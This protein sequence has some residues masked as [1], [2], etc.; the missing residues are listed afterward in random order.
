M[1]PKKPPTASVEI[2]FEEE[3]R[4]FL[5]SEANQTALRDAITGPLMETVRRLEGAIGMMEGVIKEKDETI[6]ALSDKLSERDS[7]IITLKDELHHVRQS[8]DELEQYSRRN[9]VR[10]Q[11]LPELPDEDPM[12]K[13]LEFANRTLRL[14]PPLL[15][16]DIDRAHRIGRRTTDARPRLFLIKFATYQQ[17][18]RVMKSRSLLKGTSMYVNEDLTSLRSKLMFKVRAAKRAG[19][20]T[21]CWSSDGRIF[22]KA[23]GEKRFIP[24]LDALDNLLSTAQE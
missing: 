8:C 17:R 19:K 5:F 1:P 2:D 7:T 11:G 12:E 20:L 3:F 4:K 18:L 15:P 6:K 24:A 10:V 13:T 21:D 14:N 16:S 23:N 9:S 22:A